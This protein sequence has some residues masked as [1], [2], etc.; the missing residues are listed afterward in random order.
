MAWLKK[1]VTILLV[2]AAIILAFIFIF[3]N[4]DPVTVK[5]FVVD[6][7]GYSIATWLVLSFVIGGVLGL[8]AGVPAFLKYRAFVRGMDRKVVKKDK[9]IQ[10]PRGEMLKG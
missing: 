10:K 4:P 7:K 8:L 1:I 2:L 9:Q 6:V 5:L 3:M